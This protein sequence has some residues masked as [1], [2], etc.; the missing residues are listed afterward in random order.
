M[1]DSFFE[2]ALKP[3]KCNERSMFHL[4]LR[5]LVNKHFLPGSGIQGSMTAQMELLKPQRCDVS[6]AFD[7]THI[8]QSIN[9]TPCQL[10]THLT[11]H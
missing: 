10:S 5:P 7:A 1:G 2:D 8:N 3:I 9:C 11:V 4:F 6:A